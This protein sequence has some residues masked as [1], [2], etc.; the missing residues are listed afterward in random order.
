M[1]FVV[2]D[3]LPL[4]LIFNLH[5]EKD[6]SVERANTISSNNVSTPSRRAA[7]HST[8][9]NDRAISGEEA[10]TGF[11]FDDSERSVETSEVEDMHSTLLSGNTHR[12]KSGEVL[13]LKVSGTSAKSGGKST[14]ISSENPGV[15]KKH[16][17]GQLF[18]AFM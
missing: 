11:V 17:S 8:N 15:R 16:S 3:F 6:R 12:G 7:T 9:K 1:N 5:L 2:F 14:H 10:F 13:D 18:G 4:L